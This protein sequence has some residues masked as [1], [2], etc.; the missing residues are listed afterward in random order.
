MLHGAHLCVVAF[1]AGF[2]C[3]DSGQSPAGVGSGAIASVPGVGP[4]NAEPSVTPKNLIYNVV[5]T[6]GSLYRNWRQR[7]TGDGLT[8]LLI[9][10][11]PPG[12]VVG[13]TVRVGLFPEPPAF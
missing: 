5:S 11:N 2:G 12:V 6:P 1:T 10:G 7:Q 8:R 9:V 4:G 13:S 3:T